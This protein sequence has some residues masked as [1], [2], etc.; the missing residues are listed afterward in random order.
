MILHLKLS[1]HSQ[2]NVF[3]PSLQKQRE[4]ASYKSRT[5]K[6]SSNA[7]LTSPQLINMASALEEQG[8]TGEQ[9]SLDQRIPAESRRSS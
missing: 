1:L 5:H 7:P 6:H 2:T 4:R 3:S 9:Q 8:S